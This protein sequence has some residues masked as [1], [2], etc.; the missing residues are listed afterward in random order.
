MAFVGKWCSFRRNRPL[1]LRDHRV[2]GTFSVL[3]KLAAVRTGR[4]WGLP[5][6]GRLYQ[7]L[8]RQERTIMISRFPAPVWSVPLMRSRNQAYRSL[9]SEPS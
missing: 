5:G 9:G 7:Q 3:K 6:H 2:L 8:S 1:L 4:G